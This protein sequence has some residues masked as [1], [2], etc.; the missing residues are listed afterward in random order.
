MT[1]LQKKED[2][3]SDEEFADVEIFIRPT[4][5]EHGKHEQTLEAD[6]E[7]VAQMSTDHIVDSAVRQFSTDEYK[8]YSVGIRDAGAEVMTSDII[9]SES[10]TQDLMFVINS[11]LRE[12]RQ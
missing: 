2:P 1:G 8:H 9:V 4:D 7:S 6:Y 5:D 10:A 3:L 12:W 11:L